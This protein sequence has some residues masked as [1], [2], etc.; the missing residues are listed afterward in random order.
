VVIKPN[1][2]DSMRKDSASLE[3]TVDT[4][5]TLQQIPTIVVSEVATLPALAATL[6][7]S[8][9]IHLLEVRDARS[10]SYWRGCD[11]VGLVTIPG[12]AV[13]KYNILQGF[14]FHSGHVN[15]RLDYSLLPST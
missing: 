1:H 13:N 7:D 8:G 10:V 6:E 3:Q 5:M 15:C 14:Y 9:Q 12:S 11:A 2:V 4:V